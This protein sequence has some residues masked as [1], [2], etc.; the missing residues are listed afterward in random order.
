MAENLKTDTGSESW[1]YNDDSSLIETY[2]RLYS[3]NTAV[4]AC[5]DGWRL[6]AHNELNLLVENMGGN[7]DDW[8]AITRRIAP[9]LG[10]NVSAPEI[11]SVYDF[12][13]PAAGNYCSLNFFG[14]IL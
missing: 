2:G 8:L 3:W 13:R 12:R 1:A 5:P 9:S 6:P 4:E 7:E 14:L 10:G 11:L